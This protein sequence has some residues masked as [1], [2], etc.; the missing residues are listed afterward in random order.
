LQA[1][2]NASV[3]VPPRRPAGA[4]RPADAGAWGPH[5]TAAWTACRL[6]TVPDVSGD[7]PRD[8]HRA[9]PAAHREPDL[10]KDLPPLPWPASIAATRDV[11]H[12]RVPHPGA[13]PGVAAPGAAPV[14][15]ST[16]AP[17]HG[18]G[19]GHQLPPTAALSG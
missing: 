5:R 4:R 15:Q 19:P 13:T 10:V 16:A 6:D 11:D 3:A 18:G 17:G 14:A 12:R 1:G 7:G 2:G 9:A 8:V